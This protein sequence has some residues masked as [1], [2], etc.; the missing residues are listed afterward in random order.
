[1]HSI[2]HG[3]IHSAIVA[4]GFAVFAPAGVRADLPT[5]RLDVL[6]PAGLS[7]GNSVEVTITGADLDGCETLLCGH[8]GLRA[9]FV[10][11]RTFKLTAAADVPTGSYDVYAA[12]RFGVTNPRL[13]HVS[14]GLA[15]VAEVEPNNSRSS[16]QLVAINVAVNG[17]ADGNNQDFY[18]LPLKAGQRI[19]LDCLSARL[20]T[21]M[22]PVLALSAPDGRPVA[23]NADYH[24][25]DPL[26]DFAATADG[27]YVVEVRDLTYRGGYPYRLLIHDRPRVEQ[28]FPRVVKAGQTVEL[29]ALG[30]NLGDGAQRSEFAVTD[31]PLDRKPVSYA[32]PTDL[33]PLG[34]FRF[35][36]HPLQHSVLP[37]AAT[38]TLVGE[39]FLPFDADPMVMVVT[40]LDPQL[41]QE[42]NDAKDS[43][44]KV[45]LPAILSARFDKSR[46]VDWYA[47][48]TD[49]MGG[50]Y[51]FDIYAERIDGHCDPYL[52]LY[53]DAGNRFFEL[54][55]FGHRMGP[56]DGHL[57][58]PAG[59]TNLPGN[60]T[61][62]VMVQDRYQ[63]GGVRTQYVLSI[64]KAKS[65]FFAASIHSNGTPVGLTVWQ[66]GAIEI[67]VVL[68]HVDGGNQFPVTVTAEN[69]PAGV[70]MTPT[71]ITNNHWGT[72]VLWADDAAPITTAPIKLWATSKHGDR[73]LRREVRPHT[74]AYQQVGSRPMR[75]Q[76]LAV[77]ERA[78]YALR[79]E[80]ER[81]TVEAGK[82]AELKLLLT[83]HW[84]DFTNAVNYQPLVF[85][86]QF[87]LGNG[88]IN[89]GQ[90]EAAMSIMV[91][92]GTP[93]GDYTL[94]VLGQAQVPFHKAPTE[95]NRPP[96]LV[97]MP[98]RPVTITVTAAAK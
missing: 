72:A 38:C 21:E 86:G 75:E 91:Q 18:R 12:G 32:A 74:R 28:V 83:R 45:T 78:P 1:M 70:H 82:P 3:F 97:A 37:T 67:P 26:I 13:V 81:I 25:R 80:P 89:A 93:P 49:E 41:E 85:P 98:S 79:L 17:Q 92:P 29:T 11:E 56:F 69:L 73:E 66:G 8:P 77:R 53:D 90:T 7:A 61:I 88:A 71:V 96:T 22:D 47:F 14:R 54:D 31:L 36:Q 20:E 33:L 51:G 84:P 68:H 35:R 52:A 30:T 6:Q 94:A 43:P 60:K 64:R 42:P 24:G 10:K 9:E 50:A 46:D 76:M 2:S 5:P 87:Q 65:D 58:D 15:D 57:R 62:R 40:D 55:D 48:E 27:D 34:L 16:A 95:K 63:R 39:Q 59:Q 44:Q 4:C 23:S 19:T